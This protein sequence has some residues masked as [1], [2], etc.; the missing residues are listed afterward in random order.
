MQDPWGHRDGWNLY[1]SPLKYPDRGRWFRNKK[2]ACSIRQHPHYQSHPK[3]PDRPRTIQE[4]KTMVADIPQRLRS[5]P[6]PST[7]L[8]NDCTVV[9]EAVLVSWSAIWHSSSSSSI[10]SSS[11]SVSYSF[12]ALLAFSS[13]SSFSSLSSLLR[14]SGTRGRGG[15][16]DLGGDGDETMLA[17]LGWFFSF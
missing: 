3:Y 9:G 7:W 2:K 12:S 4:A 11:S 15:L 8:A 10:S 14:I 5:S 13:V 1:K 6:Q 16:C 17:L